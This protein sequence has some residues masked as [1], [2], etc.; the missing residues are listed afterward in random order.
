MSLSNMKMS[1]YTRTNLSPGDTNSRN[2]AHCNNITIQESDNKQKSGGE[3]N[4]STCGFLTYEMM[5]EHFYNDAVFCLTKPVDNINSMF[6]L[7]YKPM[8]VMNNLSKD[9]I[10]NLTK[11]YSEK[12]CSANYFYGSGWMDKLLCVDK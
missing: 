11:K 3:F 6:N 12:G 10:N 5:E 7:L 9:E 4:I 1:S 8:V 2:I